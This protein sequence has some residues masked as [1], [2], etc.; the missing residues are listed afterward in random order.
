VLD[1]FYI[2]TRYPNGLPD[3]TPAEAFTAD[4]AEVCLEYAVGYRA[5]LPGV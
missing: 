3:L 2:P 1:R 4:D 5:D